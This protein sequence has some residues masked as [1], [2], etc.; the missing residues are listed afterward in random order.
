LGQHRLFDTVI[1]HEQALKAARDSLHSVVSIRDFLTAVQVGSQTAVDMLDK[2]ESKILEVLQTLNEDY[3]DAPW[4][5]HCSRL[6]PP[7]C[8]SRQDAHHPGSS[9]ERSAR[10]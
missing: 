2:V 10:T 4:L 7:A 9:W 3:G 6:S 8:S 1:D 5:S